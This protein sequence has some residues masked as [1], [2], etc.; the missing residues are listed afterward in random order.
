MKR[1]RANR[2][3]KNG[4]LTATIYYEDDSL[5]LASSN[6][7]IQ[8][9][10]DFTPV[11]WSHRIDCTY[12]PFF[13]CFKADVEIKIGGQ[14]KF[15]INDGERYCLSQRYSVT[16]DS[17]GSHKNNVFDPKKIVRGSKAATKFKHISF[18]DSQHFKRSS[19]YNTITA[20]DCV[21]KSQGSFKTNRQQSDSDQV[22]VEWQ[23]VREQYQLVD[24]LDDRRLLGLDA[25]NRQQTMAQGNSF[26]D[27]EE[28]DAAAQHA[29]HSR[30]STHTTS[31]LTNANAITII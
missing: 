28:R 27:P 6:L 11:P 20:P 4:L 19:E 12:D 25:E 23:P 14:F 29:G 5:Q 13:D 9:F 3:L 22:I 17:T 7:K 31:A 30:D 18:A 26:C 2:N 8:V 21:Q 1:A 24:V 15:I 16:D 10:G